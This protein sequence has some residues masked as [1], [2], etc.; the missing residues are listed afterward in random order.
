MRNLTT[1]EW[2]FVKK[3]PEE[4]ALFFVTPTWFTKANPDCNEAM[5]GLLRESGFVDFDRLGFGEDYRVYVSAVYP[6]GSP[7]L[8]T[9]YRTRTRGDKRINLPSLKTHCDAGDVM[10]LVVK[11]GRVCICNVTQ[12]RGSEI[13]SRVQ[14]R[15]KQANWSEPKWSF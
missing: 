5:R 7:T 15:S 2:A 10:A 14:T 1:A 13:L 3:L 9:L 11:R 8:L 4:H 6:D 12:S